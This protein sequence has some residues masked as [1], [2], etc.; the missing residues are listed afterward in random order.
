MTKIWLTI[1]SIHLNDSFGRCPLFNSFLLILFIVDLSLM[2]FLWSDGD[3]MSTTLHD[4]IGGWSWRSSHQ[5]LWVCI[6]EKGSNN[7]FE[8]ET[9]LNGIEWIKTTWCHKHNKKKMTTR[10]VRV[11]I[12]SHPSRFSS[13]VCMLHFFFY[14]FFIQKKI[15]MVRFNSVFYWH[16]FVPKEKTQSL[17][18]VH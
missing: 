7:G 3:V 8:L 16:P 12:S 14:F 11:Q 1:L 13:P 6:Y 15:A 18:K 10:Q 2:S 9:Q 17:P 4:V 5:D